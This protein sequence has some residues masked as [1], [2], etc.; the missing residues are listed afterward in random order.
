MAMLVY[1]RVFVLDVASVQQ[2]HSLQVSEMVSE[3]YVMQS[4]HLVTISR[5]VSVIF[6][7]YHELCIMRN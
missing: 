6:M 5:S 7:K 1:Q 2:L 4:M 3:I